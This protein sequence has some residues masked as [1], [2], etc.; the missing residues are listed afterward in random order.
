M[1]ISQYGSLSSIISYKKALK[2]ARFDGAEYVVGQY[3]S[4]DNIAVNNGSIRV[5]AFAG[6]NVGGLDTTG[7]AKAD[8]A[9]S[10][11]A[12]LRQHVVIA[13]ETLS[14]IAEQYDLHSGSIVLANPDMPDTEV[15]KIGQVLTIPAADA[16]PEALEKEFS[17]RQKK[18]AIKEA[19]AAIST[20]ATTQKKGTALRKSAGFLTPVSY[21]YISQHFSRSH[22]GI[23]Y[24]ASIG[25]P[26]K[27]AQAG[28]VISS[29]GGWNG[30][31]GNMIHLSHGGGISTLYAHLSSFASSI[32]SGSCVSAGDVIGYVG[33]TGRSTGA[34]LHFEYRVNGVPSAF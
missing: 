5:L 6:Q 3:F 8:V 26:I 14:G 15:L 10:E 11:G 13:G 7:T 18:I 4:P 25:T 23:D 17:D 33:S 2:E 1:A 21:N 32:R 12:G 34:H 29:G 9:T 24:V 16:S 20:K 30:G 28:C 31:Y 22:S 19:K 27:A